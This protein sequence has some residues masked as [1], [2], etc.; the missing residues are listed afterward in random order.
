[1]KSMMLLPRAISTSIRP[2]SIRMPGPQVNG[3]WASVPLLIS[4][5]RSVTLPA[6]AKRLLH[7][8]VSILLLGGILL[9]GSRGGLLATGVAL[10]V[11]V[12]VAHRGRAVLAACGLVAALVAAFVFFT[13]PYGVA[14][15]EV[16]T[17]SSSGRTDIWQ[18]GL[19]AC[20]E[21]CAFGS[22]WGTFPTVYADTQ[23]SVPDARVL[24][25]GGAYEPHNVWI[26]VG[27]EL[28][29]LGIVLLAAALLASFA[30]AWRLPAGLRSPPLA[31]LAATVFAATFLSNLEFKFFWMALMLVI[32]CRNLTDPD[33]APVAAIDPATPVS[34]FPDGRIARSNG[35]G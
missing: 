13:N 17:T 25:G 10:V 23:A 4:I 20:P 35:A 19:T 12:A 28:G 33:E 11:L 8:V 27:I 2:S 22:G 18:V 9:T 6:R 32:L 34:T 31:G 7:V 15:R 3:F 30:E 29:V 1:M 5:T 16:E 26:L 21:Y 24:V 14:E